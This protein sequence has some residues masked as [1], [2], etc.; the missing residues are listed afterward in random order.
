LTIAR[1]AVAVA[2]ALAW[3]GAAA[4]AGPGAAA[5]DVPGVR[6]ILPVGEGG[7]A[8]ALDLAA[9]E[10]TGATPPTFTNQQAAFDA[11][12]TDAPHMTDGLIA[13]D[14]P[15]AGIGL[16]GPAARVE[17]PAAGVTISWD[18]LDVPHISAQTVQGA[19]FGAGY[20]QAEARLF[21][22][23]ALRHLGRGRLTELAGP[24]AGNSNLLADEAVRSQSDY[25]DAELQAQV[26][27]LPAEF[28]AQGALVLQMASA[29]T[30]GINARIAADRANPLLMP[31]EY[32]AVGATP[33]RWTTADSVAIGA[34]INQG[35]DVGG[36]AQ[37]VDGEMV[38]E[39]E[40]RLGRRAGDR[41]FGDISFQDSPLSP[42]TT[43][44]RFTY[45]E[46]DR[47]EPSA[48]AMPDPDSVQPITP[49][50]AAGG[51]AAD[52]PTPRRPA[53]ISPGLSRLGR[54]GGDSYAVLVGGARSISGR[55]IADMGPQLDFFSPE[56]VMEESLQAPGLAVAGAALPGVAPVPIAGHT[57]SFAWSVTIG[58]GE[59]ID[60]FALTLCSR[61][62]SPVTRA[63][64]SYVY[65]GACVPML[66]RTD[67]ETT[68]TSANNPAP[69]QTFSIRTLRSVYGPVVATGTIRGAPVA[70]ARADATYGHLADTIVPLAEIADGAVDSAQ[71]F[72]RLVRAAPFSLNWFYVDRAHI[73]WTLSGRYPRHR[74]VK[75]RTHGRTLTAGPSPVAP[76]PGT[77][78]WD[79]P[80]FRSDATAPGGMTTFSGDVA[81]GDRLPHAIDPPSGF[82]ANWNNKPAPGWRASDDDYYFGP[83]HRVS[84]YRRRLG[85]AFAAAAGGRI[86][87]ANLVSLVE[88][89]DL[90]DLRGSL[91]LPWLLRVAGS[92]DTT[93]TRQLIAILR[94]WVASGAHIRDLNGDGLDDDGPANR[95]MDAWWPLLVPAV[96]RPVLGPDAYAQAT[97]PAFTPID[98]PPPLD[99]EAWYDGWYGQVQQDMRDVVQPHA[100]GRFSRVYCGGT[101]R[102]SG[103][104]ASC[105]RLLL[106]TLAAAAQAVAAAQG[107]PDPG[108][109]K[110]PATCP[111]PA[112][113]HP[114]CDE[115]VFTPTGAIGI[116]PVPWQNRPT[117]QQVVA[118][119]R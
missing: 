53:P 63:S 10:V 104:L 56:I 23:D 21:T 34:E 118:F 117:Y 52:R 41:A 6:D 91:V 112:T 20:A 108:A 109:W 111:V 9:Y 2:A 82:I 22:M 85:A 81:A 46:P 79:W 114:S 38:S 37:A 8:S 13:Q 26:N 100:A 94:A 5:A 35:F 70:F 62:G 49:I 90:V 44:A 101:P 98:D 80:G 33:A 25:T 102:R 57:G 87:E 61:D 50:V 60:L 7:S 40:R 83:V 24:G 75:V 110:L 29:Y 96:F 77:G 106:T 97:M 69:S 107:T 51:Q 3:H 27:A 32:V 84:L 12:V 105:R 68:T 47:I 115:I 113:G 93:Q 28:G 66:R 99:A 19:M 31:A 64:T 43:S 72:V 116:P 54:R 67:I 14:F 16:G 42:T 1:G 39:L 86:D 11:L 65:R 74:T 55:P 36:G 59:H 119:L 89:A 92:G 17:T 95:V 88:D 78:A 4:L 48:V 76:I 71:S 58:V 73:A 30:A 18:G 15:G 103:S 45:P